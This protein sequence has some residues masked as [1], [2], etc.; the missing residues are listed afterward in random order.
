MKLFKHFYT[1]FVGYVLLIFQL[2]LYAG[3]LFHWGVLYQ[4]TWFDLSILLVLAIIAIVLY[5]LFRYGLYL[6]FPKVYHDL[7][8]KQ[9]WN[10]AN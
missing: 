4:C 7:D 10:D 5:C 2:G 6:L 1:W 9:G 3:K 8:K